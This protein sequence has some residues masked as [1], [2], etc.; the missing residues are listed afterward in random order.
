MGPTGLDRRLGDLLHKLLDHDRVVVVDHEPLSAEGRSLDPH[1]GL[2]CDAEG[3]LDLGVPVRRQLG[4][5][6][7]DGQFLVGVGPGLGVL[8]RPQEGREDPL[9][10]TPLGRSDR[11]QTLLDRHGRE[12]N[13][14]CGL[15]GR[16]LRPTVRPAAAQR[17]V[18]AKP[19][20]L[21]LAGS[22]RQGVQE[23]R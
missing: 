5:M 4:G 19:Q 7:L 18:H 3:D 23:L 1:T 16:E 17:Q 12:A 10:V 2:A 8:P 9:P 11:C 22:E 15:A 13:P 6:V 20:F 21:G 14:A